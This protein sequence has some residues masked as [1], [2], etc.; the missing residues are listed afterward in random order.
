MSMKSRAPLGWSFSS[1]TC[2]HPG[3]LAGGMGLKGISPGRR[4]HMVLNFLEKR[5]LKMGMRPN[6]SSRSG[7]AFLLSRE[8]S[9]RWSAPC[10]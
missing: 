1:M 8:N 7:A 2:P 6:S 4:R 9:S 5:Y 10:L 3:R